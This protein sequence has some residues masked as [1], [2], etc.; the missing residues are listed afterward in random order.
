MSQKQEKNSLENETYTRHFD[1]SVHPWGIG[2]RSL[3][4]Q[5]ARYILAML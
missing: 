5:S 3:T 4:N 1:I 2:A